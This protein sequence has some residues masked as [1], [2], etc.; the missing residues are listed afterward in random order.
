MQDLVEQS[1]Q[2][3][4]DKLQI[5]ITTSAVKSLEEKQA[6][7]VDFCSKQRTLL[8]R[9]LGLIR[10]ASTS[11]DFLDKGVPPHREIG[12]KSR[13]FNVAADA[14]Y[15]IWIKQQRQPV[16]IFSLPVS[17]DVQNSGSYHRLPYAIEEGLVEKQR[18]AIRNIMGAKSSDEETIAELRDFLKRT[19][20]CLRIPDKSSVSK[21][22]FH[23]AVLTI[24]KDM[25]YSVDILCYQDETGNVKLRPVTLDF[26]LIL[27]RR[28]PAHL[29]DVTDQQKVDML[30]LIDEH[31]KKMESSCLEDVVALL[32]RET[33]QLYMDCI[34]EYALSDMNEVVSDS[35]GAIK[36]N[37]TDDGLRVYFWTGCNALLPEVSV[38]VKIADAPQRSGKRLVV[39]S[40]L[41]GECIDSSTSGTDLLVEGKGLT[42]LPDVIREASSR[43]SR[44]HLQKVQRILQGASVIAKEIDFFA[45]SPQLSI[46]L[47]KTLHLRITMNPQLGQFKIAVT[48]DKFMEEYQPELQK[49]EQMLDQDMDGIIAIYRDIF[50]YAQIHTQ[51]AAAQLVGLVAL[52]SLPFTGGVPPVSPLPGHAIS[53]YVPIPKSPHLYLVCLCDGSAELRFA[54][55]TGRR[56]QTGIEA[57]KL[58]MLKE[59]DI[60]TRVVGSD[61]LSP[62]S[63]A[64]QMKN[65]LVLVKLYQTV[66]RFVKNLEKSKVKYLHPG[67][68]RGVTPDTVIFVQNLASRIHP[69]SSMVKFMSLA[70]FTLN[71]LEGDHISLTL[72]LQFLPSVKRHV[73]RSWLK[74]V[75]ESIIDSRC[76]LSYE[77][78]KSSLSLK[79]LDWPSNA[80]ESA[81]M[82]L[83]RIARVWDAAVACRDF[84]QYSDTSMAV[85]DFECSMYWHTFSF[86]HKS[87]HCSDALVTWSRE[88]GRYVVNFAAKNGTSW[89]SQ[90]L[91][92]RS[93]VSDVRDLADL[94]SLFASLWR[95]QPLMRAISGINETYERADLTSIAGTI[96][97]SMMAKDWSS[98]EL[99]WHMTGR[100][101]Y[102]CQWRMHLTDSSM[103]LAV[104]V[105]GENLTN[106]DLP[107]EHVVSGAVQLIEDFFK[108]RGWY[109]RKNEKGTAVYGDVPREEIEN[110]L[111]AL[112]KAYRNIALWVELVQHQ[113][114][115]GASVT[116]HLKKEKTVPQKITVSHEGVTAVFTLNPA[117]LEMEIAL[118][119]KT[120]TAKASILP[121][122]NHQPKQ[123]TLTDSMVNIL[124]Q[125]VEQN[126]VNNDRCT[127]HEWHSLLSL[128]LIPASMVHDFVCLCLPG[129][130]SDD[131]NTA[132]F[133]TMKSA[134]DQF[135]LRPELLL[136]TSCAL[137]P[138]KNLP[139]PGLPALQVVHGTVKCLVRLSNRQRPDDFVDVPLVHD[140]DSNVTTPWEEE[141]GAAVQ[142]NGDDAVVNEGGGEKKRTLG[143]L[144]G[145]R[146]KARV[147]MTESHCAIG[148]VLLKA[149]SALDNGDIMSVVNKSNVT[150]GDV[151][152]SH[153][154]KGLLAK[155]YVLASHEVKELY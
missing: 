148:D 25:E 46:S 10:W 125:Y 69:D 29:Q 65:A 130:A 132:E 133:E 5:M 17:V 36:L 102:G 48:D 50:F 75:H 123:A 72:Q 141:S 94:P 31:L 59:E 71:V 64:G 78:S 127:I 20:T 104:E 74:K 113:W 99:F 28:Y 40:E 44:I 139:R 7:L 49:M 42:F 12:E 4:Y 109:L 134:M 66:N 61:N 86:S 128:L 57:S 143:A 9:L 95:I 22:E 68:L 89:A 62:F 145:Q 120:A 8:S 100:P 32:D 53:T 150:N 96:T 83:N 101:G 147:T 19:L 55:L 15:G 106:G 88:Q 98:W 154:G 11:R 23:D 115:E 63:L 45:Q 30:A 112:A 153:F 138:G 3:F 152:H 27:D 43:V 6:E 137:P 77:P 34:L 79:F 121:G 119:K 47:T 58:I 52:R 118:Q 107:K 129:L 56:K 26:Q 91:F 51:I 135:H 84:L 54:I 90:S 76:V 117:E 39:L 97:Y 122:L 1:L 85:D 105:I 18:L 33:M 92:E 116:P 2:R 82:H 136:T 14:L 93:L 37:P 60:S 149:N 146:K 87:G 103:R 114:P 155:I 142:Q 41:G 70:T 80:V 16:P 111:P 67:A 81:I 126:G 24:T 124:P 13:V 110:G 131:A 38:Y 35:Y 73:P 108:G 151:D 140:A 144:F 21:M